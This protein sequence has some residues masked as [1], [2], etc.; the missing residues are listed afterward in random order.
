MIKLSD[1]KRDI[2]F[3]GLLIALI[4]IAINQPKK[5]FEHPVLYAPAEQTRS[6]ASVPETDDSAI[7][8]E[9]M[10]FDSNADNSIK[11]T[12]SQTTHAIDQEMLNHIELAQSHI[13]QLNG[14]IKPATKKNTQLKSIAQRLVQLKRAYRH[15]SPAIALLGPIGTA[16]IILKE[17]ELEKNFLKIV[18]VMRIL[19]QTLTHDQNDAPAYTS[20]KQGLEHNTILLTSLMEEHPDSRQSDTFEI[21]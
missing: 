20:I 3:F 15:T 19:L 7:Q 9:T 4:N 2:L 5:T 10:V 17:T 12:L 8:E 16:G 6:I 18:N 21:S 1:K 14:F 13:D 11:A